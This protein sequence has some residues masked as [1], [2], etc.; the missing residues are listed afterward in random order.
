MDYKGK[1]KEKEVQVE[2]DYQGKVADLKLEIM[3]AKKRFE[4]RVEEFRKQ[5]DDYKKNNDVIDELKK[6]H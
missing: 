6:A 4:Q 3:D 1:V 5:I 2:K